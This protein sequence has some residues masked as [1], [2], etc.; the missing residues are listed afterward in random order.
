M[1]EVAR[2][3]LIGALRQTIEGEFGSDFDAVTWQ[4]E[5]EAEQAAWGVSPLAA[6]V[7]FYAARE[8][9]RNAARY[10]R[11][12]DA[13]RR[14]RLAISATWQNG[15]E[16]AIEDDGVG[17]AA[18]HAEPAARSSPA[19]PWAG[20]TTRGTGHGLGLHSALMAVVG[21]TLTAESKPGAYTRVSLALPQSAWV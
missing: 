7:C 12:G 5:P 21:G 4:V 18:G 16:L 14:L 20:E 17:M 19:E 10:G 2:L 13:A 3:G 1:P 9:V 6:E 8:A 11:A 15:L